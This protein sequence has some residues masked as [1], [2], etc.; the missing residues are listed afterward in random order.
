MISLHVGVEDLHTWAGFWYWRELCSRPIVRDVIPL[1]VSPWHHPYGAKDRVNILLSGGDT[2]IS[3]KGHVA[4][5]GGCS[6]RRGRVLFWK[7]DVFCHVA[8]TS[9]TG[10]TGCT[11]LNCR[12]LFSCL[13][14][15]DRVLQRY[16]GEAPIGSRPGN[17]GH[18]PET[19]FRSLRPQSL[20]EADCLHQI[21]AVADASKALEGI[22]RLLQEESKY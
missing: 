16:V 4:S 7:P 15:V 17:N 2:H 20:G 19:S 11:S 5:R 1:P 14:I 13:S 9:Y 3:S 8:R 21:P 6:R 18:L 22:M 12:N 10:T